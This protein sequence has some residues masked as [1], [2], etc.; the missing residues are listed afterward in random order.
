MMKQA[1]LA[2]QDRF[3]HEANPAAIPTRSDSAMPTLKKR[4]GNFLAKKS[5]R[6]E[7]WTSPSRTTTSESCSPNLANASPKA[8]RVDLPIF[9]N[10]TPHRSWLRV[11]EG[12]GFIL[13]FFRQRLPVM[14]RVFGQQM[15]DRVSLHRAGDEDAGSALG[16]G[17]FLKGRYDLW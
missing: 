4:S 10:H 3:P 1:K 17:G 13:L 9:M 12:Q 15:L 5:V 14:I 7:L 16:L 11:Y 2:S 6:V 8:S